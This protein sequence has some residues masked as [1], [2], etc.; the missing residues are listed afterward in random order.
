MT[1]SNKEKMHAKHRIHIGLATDELGYIVPIE[2][3]NPKDYEESMSAS[4]YLDPL[5]HQTLENMLTL[6]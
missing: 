1:K 4:K 5:I 6:S 2:D 3:Y